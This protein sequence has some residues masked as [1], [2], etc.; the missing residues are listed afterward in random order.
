MAEAMNRPVRTFSVGFGQ[1]SFDE[2]PFARKVAGC[3]RTEH[4]ELV[5]EAPVT[6]ILSRLVWHYDEPF[7]DSSAVPSYA[8]AELTR[9]HVTVVLNGDGADE[10]F[11]GY[12]WYKMDRLIQRGEILPLRL[13]QRFAALT[14][15][16]TGNGSKKGTLWKIARL[17]NVLA[18]SQ[19]RRYAQ[20]SEH[21]GP[22][23]RGQL[24]SPAFKEIVKDSNP[25][26]LFAAAFAATDA[27]DW[28]DTVLDA[29]V[30][31]YLTDDLLVK[32]D[33]AT[34]SH[35]LEAR[36]P[37][38]DHVFME[39]VARLPVAFKQAWGQKKRILKA[40]LRGRI[41]DKLL[42]R[43]KMGFSV[44]LAEWF[45]TDLRELTHDVLLSTR[46]S[47]RGYFD[48]QEVKK[49]LPG[50]DGPADHSTRLWDLLMLEL[51]HQTFIDGAGSCHINASS[52]L[53]QHPP[54]T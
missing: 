11:G 26:S 24:Y 46:A 25:D 8:I 52:V 16:F 20:W 50:H 31:L 1:A 41:P 17:A 40:S 53:R 12:D 54:A 49:L 38:L 51:W 28:L 43:P 39:F 34:M 6:D 47:Q 21:F 10:T 5:V 13:R 3:Y 14:Q 7:G 29:D 27:R 32:M 33:R 36:S 15:G 48:P 23:A 37:F 4:T 22:I 44:P 42:D 19:E 9:Q 35:S 30:N 45:R 2:R 18:L